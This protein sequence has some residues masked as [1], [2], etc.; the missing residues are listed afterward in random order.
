M[1]VKIHGK[2]YKTVAERINDLQKDHSEYAISTELIS[3]KDNVVIMKATIVTEN[4]TASGYAEEVR[5]ST[6]INKTSALENCETSAVG[7]ALAF[8]G[9]AGSEIASADEV[10]AAINNQLPQKASDAQLNYIRTLSGDKLKTVL[11]AHDLDKLP[12]ISKDKASEI[13]SGLKE[14]KETK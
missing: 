12:G 9:Y 10:A 6:T 8:F 11:D 7:R 1:P 13:I 14:A 4:K 2:D 5:G 3:D